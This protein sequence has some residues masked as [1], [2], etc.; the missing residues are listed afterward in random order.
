[1]YCNYIYYRMNGRFQIAMHILTLLNRANNELL[2][3]EY[4]AGSVNTNPALIRKEL[5][6]L[7][8]N[9]LII[10]K[11]GKSGGY[12]LA[13]SPQ[14]IK[15]SDI[16]LSVKQTSILGQAKNLPNPNCSVGKQINNHLD[17]LYKEMD[18][19]LLKKLDLTT[20]A[21]FSEQFD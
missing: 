16:Y 9:G 4:I 6:N 12:G 5:S 2:S 14:S 1:L 20:L 7:R 11:E 10:S 15:L 19:T 8:N 13:K 3:S 17:N 21:E 18:N